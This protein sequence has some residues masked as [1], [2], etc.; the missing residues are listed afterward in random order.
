MERYFSIQAYRHVRGRMQDC[1]QNILEPTDAQFILHLNSL[2]LKLII[3][4]FRPPIPALF[5]LSLALGQVIISLRHYQLIAWV[6]TPFAKKIRALTKVLLQLAL[7]QE[8]LLPSSHQGYPQIDSASERAIAALTT[9]PHR[10]Q[11]RK[12]RPKLDLRPVCHGENSEEIGK[13]PE[14]IFFSS[15]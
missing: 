13:N 15:R 12:P 7:Q 10:Q 3:T 8:W 2:N 1:V 14:G 11:G 5:V 4:F 9:T 6:F